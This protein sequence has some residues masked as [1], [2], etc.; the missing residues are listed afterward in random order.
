ME[1]V[2]EPLTYFSSRKSGTKIDTVIIHYISAINVTPDKPHSAKECIKI[3]KNNQVSAHYMIDLKGLI[4]ELIPPTLKA[5]HAGKSK[6][7]GIYNL[8]ENSIGIELIGIGNKDFTEPQYSALIELLKDI[9]SKYNIEEKNLIGHEHVSPGRK[10]DPGRY[11]SWNRVYDAL[12]RPEDLP[13]ETP[14][15]P[16]EEPKAPIPAPEPPP[17]YSLLQRIIKALFKIT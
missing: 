4:Y 6:W 5:W 17:E 2:Q 15:E 9:V 1:I 3:L 14:I 7:M 11:F 13:P 8:N 12:Y 10:V 16:T